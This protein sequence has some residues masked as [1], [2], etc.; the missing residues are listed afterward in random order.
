MKL[1]TRLEQNTLDINAIREALSAQGLGYR[2]FDWWLMDHDLET[3]E[4]LA[5]QLE[6]LALIPELRLEQGLG[7]V[8]TWNFAEYMRGV[9]HTYR[10]AAFFVR[11]EMA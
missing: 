6:T 11:G 5:E 4:D 1:N 3:R 8:L 2:S 9:A 10:D 7:T